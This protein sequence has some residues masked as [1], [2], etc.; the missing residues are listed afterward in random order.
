MAEQAGQHGALLNP[1][2]DVRLEDVRLMVALLKVADL[3]VALQVGALG[4]VNWAH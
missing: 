1:V 3:E 2:R 4:C